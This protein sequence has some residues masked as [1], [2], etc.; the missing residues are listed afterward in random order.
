VRLC[1]YAAGEGAGAG[2][3]ESE[4]SAGVQVDVKDKVVVRLYVWTQ[5][6]KRGG[7]QGY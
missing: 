4:L 2:I 1:V 3:Q 7:V 5:H 6:K